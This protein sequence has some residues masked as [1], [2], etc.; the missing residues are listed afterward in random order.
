MTEKKL[1]YRESL[2]NLLH[3]M[4]AEP[5]PD[6]FVELVC[7]WFDD[8]YLPGF[9]SAQYT[10]EANERGIAEFN[11]CFRQSE[12]EALDRFHRFFDAR[13]DQ[14]PDD[15]SPQELMANDQWQRIRREAIKT[16]KAFGSGENET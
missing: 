4:A 10:P 6:S 8:L 16:L 15:A 7:S 1:Y 11:N 5:P 14:M 13:V 2:V 3:E 12:L 9:D